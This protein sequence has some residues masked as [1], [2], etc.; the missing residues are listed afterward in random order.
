MNHYQDLIVVY[1]IGVLLTI[2]HTSGWR[3]YVIMAFACIFWPLWW[4]CLVIYWL[5]GGLRK[6]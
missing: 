2:R 4:A 1:I 6:P 5:K 3:G